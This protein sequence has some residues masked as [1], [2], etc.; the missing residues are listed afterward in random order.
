MVAE[1]SEHSQAES[2][3]GRP[4]MPGAMNSAVNPAEDE[5]GEGLDGKMGRS[6]WAASCGGSVARVRRET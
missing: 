1:S 3:L 6:Q 4:E 5:R 2:I